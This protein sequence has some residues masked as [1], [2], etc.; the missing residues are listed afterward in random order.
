MAKKFLVIILQ[1]LLYTGL[2]AQQSYDT[3]ELSTCERKMVEQETDDVT[4]K[5]IRDTIYLNTDLSGGNISKA[6]V[7]D[8]NIVLNQQLNEVEQDST[9]CAPI[10]TAG[11]RIEGLEELIGESAKDIRENMRRGATLEEAIVEEIIEE[12]EKKIHT[13]TT[14]YGQHLLKRSR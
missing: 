7:P 12:K 13:K 5:I 10:D 6:E 4:Q 3:Y 14:N 1:V 9:C 8:L 2:C 11:L